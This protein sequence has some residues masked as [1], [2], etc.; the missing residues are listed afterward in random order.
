MERFA[1]ESIKE[2][3]IHSN[4]IIDHEFHEVRREGD[5]FEVGDF[6]SKIIQIRIK[7]LK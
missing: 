3:N 5:D 7:D 2:E 4:W 6:I 1:N